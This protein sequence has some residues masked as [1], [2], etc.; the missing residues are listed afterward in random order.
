MTTNVVEKTANTAAA[1]ALLEG[2]RRVSFTA[3]SEIKA[4][5]TQ[6]VW[7]GFLP[8]G[9]LSLLVGREGLGKSTVFYERAARLSRGLLPGI[10]FGQPKA[11]VVCA[12]EDAWDRTIVPRLMAHD[13]DLTRIYRVDVR[14]AEGIATGLLLPEDNEEL[15]RGVRELDAGLIGLDPLLS[16]LAPRLDSHKDGE[17][18][19]ALEP[20]VAIAHRTR[21]AVWGIIHANK[22]E[23][24]DTEN[25]IMGSRA[26][27]AVAR[28]VL[29]IV[30]DPDDSTTY[31]FGLTKSNLGK[32][33]IPG[34]TYSI[35]EAN[36]GP[37][38]DGIDITTGR[39]VW[40]KTPTSG[41]GRKTIDTLR[42]KAVNVGRSETKVSKA[43]EWLFDYL[44][45]A[46]EPVDSGKVKEDGQ[47]AGH[48]DRNLKRAATKI[49]VTMANTHTVP[50]RT[51][52]AVVP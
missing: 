31:T 9:E 47:S 6:W 10:Y 42:A 39:I 24:R 23:G 48:S 36:L 12:T 5:S 19:Q 3:A 8:L 49:G 52:W 7:N 33:H 37:D 50:R 27:P 1:K 2:K 34:Y 51:T 15:E 13:A 26:F 20:I 18:R 40:G 30:G 17:V 41:S 11:T 32:L 28:S 22:S 38:E 29:W 46:S 21:S 25:A 4:R 16:R 45:A 35:E 43:E 44:T 14:S